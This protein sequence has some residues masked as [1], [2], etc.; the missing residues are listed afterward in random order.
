M[1]RVGP[2]CFAAGRRS[3]THRSRRAGELVEPGQGRPRLAEEGRQ[4][5][6]QLL[7]VRVSLRG[8]REHGLGVAD[9]AGEL[10]LA[11]RER[12]EDVAAA[13]DQLLCGERLAVEDPQDPV[14]LLGESVERRDRDREVLAAALEGNRSALHPLLERGTGLGVE[15]AED[16]VE[17]DRLRDLRLGKRVALGQRRRRVAA[18][19]QLD[20]G[21]PEQRLLTEHRPR[22]VG[23]RRVLRIELDRRD[24]VAL[25][26]EVD[27][28]DLAD[29]DPGDPHVG[30]LGELGRLGERDLDPIALRLQRDRAAERDPQEQRQREAG[31]REAGG[32]QDPGECRWPCLHAQCSG[33]TGG[34]VSGG[35]TRGSLDFGTLV[36][37]CRV[38]R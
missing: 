2:S 21:L 5:D 27:R 33:R 36:S 28:L 16:L 30:L 34:K 38:R 31:E 23:D 25:V 35:Q 3:E 24:R 32:D 14:C 18:G 7:Q 10:A 6:E 4:D 12:L 13:A 17:L 19:G 11:L 37:C 20:V 8:R 1:P 9:Q 22:V 15:G 26:A 29:R